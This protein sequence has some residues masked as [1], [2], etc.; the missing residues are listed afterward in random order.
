M[1]SGLTN[2]PLTED[3]SLKEEDEFY[4]SVNP[5]SISTNTP[6]PTQIKSQ[7]SPSRSAAL[8]AKVISRQSSSSELSSEVAPEIV[9]WTEDMDMDSPDDDELDGSSDVDRNS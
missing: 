8:R 1:D 9:V 7:I 4:Q 6:S 3:S 2:R 5:T